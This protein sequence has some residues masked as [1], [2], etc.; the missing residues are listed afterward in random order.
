MLTVKAI[1]K[2]K[3]QGVGFRYTAMDIAKKLHLTGFAKN[4]PDGTVELFVTGDEPTIHQFFEAL[5]EAFNL[6]EE[7]IV[8]E[9]QPLEHFS[10]FEV[11]R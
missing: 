9:N 6:Q 1:A 2:G 5:R 10:T 3:V 8:I 11:R 7:Q 4:L